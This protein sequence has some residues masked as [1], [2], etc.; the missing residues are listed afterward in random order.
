MNTITI[1]F[2][3]PKNRFFP[4]FSWLIRLYE[5]TS[6]SHVFIRLHI[7]EL[8]RE[9]LFEAVGPHVRMVT[10]KEWEKTAQEVASFDVPVSHSN[11]ISILQYC[12][13]HQAAGYG[14][15]QNVGVVLADWF[16]LKH[17]PF[18]SGM[19]C[20][21]FIYNILKC[22]G[23]YLDKNKNLITPKDIYNLLNKNL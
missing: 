1:G 7:Q 8:N 10:V 16:N 9:V 2:S 12:I 4:I 23:Y 13:D 18:T 17:N 3:K 21:E 20:S 14:I 19:N 6:Y 15:M 11:Y 5:K 22:Q